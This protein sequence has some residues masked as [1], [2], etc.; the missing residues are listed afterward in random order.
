MAIQVQYRRGTGS[1]NDSFTG[2]VGEITVD[3]TAQ[4][5]R[6]HDGT[7]AAAVILQQHSMLLTVLEY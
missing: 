2:A 4:T 3:T 6:I 5:L 1:E 7:S